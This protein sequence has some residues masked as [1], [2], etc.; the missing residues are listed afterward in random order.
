MR[1]WLNLISKI[2]KEKGFK[3]PNAIKGTNRNKK[4]KRLE[5]TLEVVF[6]IILY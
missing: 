4:E 1:T 3:S 5:K 2:P 6:S